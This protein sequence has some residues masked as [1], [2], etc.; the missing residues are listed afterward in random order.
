LLIDKFRTHTFAIGL[1][2]APE[3]PSGPI[4]NS[5]YEV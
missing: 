1:R 3:Q 4:N 2:S 5:K